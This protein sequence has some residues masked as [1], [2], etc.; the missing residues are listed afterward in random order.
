MKST[1]N[2]APVLQ[3]VKRFLK[4]IVVVYIYQ[5]AKFGEIINCGSKMHLVS[6]TN[7]HGKNTK[8]WI[9][10]EPNITFLRNEQILSL[11]LR[12]HILNSYRFV[13]EVTFKRFL[14]SFLAFVLDIALKS[15]SVSFFIPASNYMLT[16]ET[17]KQVLKY[18]QS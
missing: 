8:T 10:W 1:W 4:V 14:L 5:L 13:A 3:I 12:W 9:S 2:L 18:V 7:A 6:C 15:L 17:L 11:C 16:I